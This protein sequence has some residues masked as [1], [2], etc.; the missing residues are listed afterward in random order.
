MTVKWQLSFWQTHYWVTYVKY[1][2]AHVGQSLASSYAWQE[3]M[4]RIPIYTKADN[5]I[6][7]LVTA[8]LL[9]E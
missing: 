5:S 8:G 1:P 2:N 7:R 3:L 9:L 4:W 6:A